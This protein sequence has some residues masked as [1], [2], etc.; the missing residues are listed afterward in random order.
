MRLGVVT[1][2]YPR[3]A[4]DAAGSFVAG[5]VAYLRRA[6]GVTSVEVIAADDE[7]IDRAW[8]AREGVVRV[9][10]PRGLFYAGGAPEA[11]A[12]GASRIAMIGFA[13]RL[14]AEVAA[15]GLRWD[16]VVAHWLAP[17]AI[18]ACAA[19]GPLL[20]IAHGGDVHLLA[21]LRLLGGALRLLG[22]RRARLAFVSP[23]LR[24]AAIDAWPGAADRSIVQPMAIDGDRAAAIVAARA[25]RALD[26]SITIAVLARLVPIKSID[27]AIEALVHLPPRYRLAIAGDGPLRGTLE[28]HARDRGVADRVAF[29]GWL[30]ADA[31]DRL[32]ARAEVVVVPSAPT[33]DG[34]VEGTP[35][36][37]LE[38]LAAGVPLVVSA[39]GGLVELAAHGAIAITPRD[40]R[41]L[42]RAIERARA[43]AI[44]STDPRL[45]L[46][47]HA[48]AWSTVGP[49][50][51]A[52]WRR[53]RPDTA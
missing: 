39:T 14:A 51:D 1:T 35:L 53:E 37:A 47:P 4:G 20:A 13:A 34:R 52:H 32:L 31:R 49:R 9:G 17:S 41:A 50:L 3:R 19:R 43:P 30:D 18:A 36:A 10:A 6:P 5:H 44:T 21:R 22:A 23:A 46:A 27:T 38:A 26:E 48:F 7:R 28:A 33:P 12:A 45:A 29:L 24:A 8:D 16:A 11:I 42:A 40:P 2:S 15:R 25:A